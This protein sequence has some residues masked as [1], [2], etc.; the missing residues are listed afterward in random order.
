MS[1]ASL[2]PHAFPHPAQD[3]TPD[4]KFLSFD[5]T[6]EKLEGYADELGVKSLPAFKFFKV[7]L[8]PSIDGYAQAPAGTLG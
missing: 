8:L 2:K 5:T 4:V 7:G 1:L 6:E 3:N